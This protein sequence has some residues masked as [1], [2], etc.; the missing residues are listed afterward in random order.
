MNE[1]SMEVTT[2]EIRA[3]VREIQALTEQAETNGNELAKSIDLVVAGWQGDASQAYARAYADLHMRLK[4]ALAS[5]PS[6]T[7]ALT[8]VANEIDRDE[9][10]LKGSYGE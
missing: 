1:L 5:L 2:D 6:I 4:A 7:T 3:C 10:A 9:A 8:T